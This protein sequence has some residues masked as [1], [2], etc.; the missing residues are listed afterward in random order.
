MGLKRE[1]AKLEQVEEMEEQT[2]ERRQAEQRSIDEKLVGLYRR[3]N[4]IVEYID[5]QTKEVTT[6][7]EEQLKQDE[8]H[9]RVEGIRKAWELK[10]LEL[11]Q[12]NKDLTKQL[13]EQENENVYNKGFKEGVN[14][15]VKRV[16]E[17][18]EASESLKREPLTASKGA[19]EGLKERD[20]IGL[21][22]GKRT[23]DV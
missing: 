6:I 21:G 1:I 16:R 2:E 9:F 18:R 19:T 3:I 17:T 20:K 5:N 4:I 12:K 7:T 10:N 8:Q 11:V 22:L 15:T 14:Y 23:G 13:K